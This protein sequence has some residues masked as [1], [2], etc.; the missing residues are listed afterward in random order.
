M[1]MHIYICIHVY[2]Y[3]CIYMCTYGYMYTY[4][5]TFIYIYIHIY[6]C[7]YIYILLL[8]APTPA[9]PCGIPCAFSRTY[10]ITRWQRCKEYL[11]LWISFCKRANNYRALL[12]KMAHN[13]KA[14][15]ESWPPCT[16]AIRQHY[17]NAMQHPA[18][19]CNTLRHT[20][21]TPLAPATPN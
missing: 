5:Y 10:V 16:G 4:I 18:T 21:M 6:T 13:D 17:C 2:V 7:K 12:R 20:N 1:Y 14:P 3:I 9:I 15:C 19:Y 11:E 8:R